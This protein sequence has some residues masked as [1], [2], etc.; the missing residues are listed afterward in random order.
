MF[1]IFLITGLETGKKRG[2]L[3]IIYTVIIFVI[4]ELFCVL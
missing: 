1:F 4:V 2:P 3:N